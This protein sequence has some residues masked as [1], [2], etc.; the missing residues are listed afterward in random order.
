[1]VEIQLQKKKK[2]PVRAPSDELPSGAY[3]TQTR[4]LY[5]SCIPVTIFATM[6][7]LFRFYAKRLAKSYVWWDDW[8][9]VVALVRRTTG[10]TAV[11]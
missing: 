7:V 2:K 5:A 8:L 11:E 3:D 9:I 6:A 4:S 1:V 10:Q